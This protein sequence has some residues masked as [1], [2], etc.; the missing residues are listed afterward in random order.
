MS[1]MRD[2]RGHCSRELDT[3]IVL[4]FVE[5]GH[6]HS[7]ICSTT[8]NRTVGVSIFLSQCSP[9]SR[10]H[11]IGLSGDIMRVTYL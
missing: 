11:D 8:N 4:L 3:P 2:V 6:S 10:I 1:Q 9:M 7:F 5:I